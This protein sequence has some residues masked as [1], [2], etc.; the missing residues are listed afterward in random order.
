MAG[1]EHAWAEMKEYNI[2]DID[3]LEEVYLKLRPWDSVHPNIGVNIEADSHVCSKCG[4]KHIKQDGYT[5]TNVSKYEL[6][7]CDDCGGF[8]RG[9]KSKLDKEKGKKLLTNAKLS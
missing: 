5:Y 7:K 9:R 4:S 2:Q 6:Y 8:S 1:N 3:T